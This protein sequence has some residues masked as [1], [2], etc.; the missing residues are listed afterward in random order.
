MHHEPKV[1]REEP[2]H[3]MM[4]RVLLPGTNL[5]VS[6]VCL[7]TMQFAGFPGHEAPAQEL[8]TATVKSALDSGINFFDCAEC[9]GADHAAHR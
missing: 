4:A 6:R 5:H 9:Y 2:A 1:T 3:A 8:V 7:G